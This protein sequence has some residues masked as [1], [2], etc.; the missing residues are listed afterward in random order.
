[1]VGISDCAAIAPVELL[2]AAG[3]LEVLSNA[4]QR[5]S[6]YDGVHGLRLCPLGRFVGRLY[7][8]AGDDEIYGDADDRI[9]PPEGIVLPWLRASWISAGL[10]GT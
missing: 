10:A 8:P 5:V 6:R 2:P 9:K 3:H 1:M 4:G 7:D